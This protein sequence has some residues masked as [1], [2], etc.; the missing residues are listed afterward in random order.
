MNAKLNWKIKECAYEESFVRTLSRQVN[1]SETF[2]RLCL[3]RGLDS[4]EKI[5]QFVSLE[6]PIFHD[7]FLL[8]DMEKIVDR[9]Q[10][11][12]EMGEEIVIYGDYDADGITSTTILVETLE[13]L[14]AHVGYYLPNRFTDGYGPNVRAFQSLIDRGAQLILTCDNGVSGHEAIA[15]ANT[16]GVDVV[17]TDHHELP[18]VLPEAYAI[19]H[20]RHPGASYPF[21]DLSGAGVALKL[22]AAL[23]GEIPYESLDVAAIGT[24]ADLVSLVDEN[25]WIASK[26][27]QQMRRTERLGLRMLL[28]AAGGSGEQVDEETIGFV[29]GP[30]L[31]ALG[32]LEDASPG[33][34]LLLTFEEGRAKELAQYTQTMNSK[35]QAL[36]AAISEEAISRLADKP[37]L[38][39]I[40]VLGDAGWH[41][42]VL[43][44]VASRIVEETGRPAILL[45]FD[46]QTGLAKGSA[47]SIDAVNIFQGLSRCADLLVKFGGHHM[48]AG[49]TVEIA[50]LPLLEQR[51][52]EFAEPFQVD[53]AKGQTIYVDEILDLRDA[54]L[55]FLAEMEKLKPFG[56]KN[57][58]PIFAFKDVLLQTIRQ[59]GADNKHLKFSLAS[60][61]EAHAALDVIAF[62]KGDLAPHLN[63][64][65]TVSAIGELKVNSWRDIRK[66]QL[67]LKDLKSDSR[68]IFDRRSS[69]FQ[70][71]SLEI[72]QATYLFF[73]KKAYNELKD[74]IPSTSEAVLLEAGSAF[75]V[76]EERDRVVILDCP[77]DL[78]TLR[79]FLERNRPNNLYVYAYPLYNATKE[80]M[81]T[82][83]QFAALYRYVQTHQRMAIREN[84]DALSQ[85]LKI[86]KNLLVFMLIVFLEAKFVT[87]ENGIM[88]PVP[89][90]GK[91]SLQETEAYR[92]RVKNIEAEKLFIYSP[93]TRIREWLEGN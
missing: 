26:G 13:I 36:V 82:K 68:Q 32:R 81:P 10:Q 39:D 72:E 92:N 91:V 3:Q 64:A 14:G 43:G 46:Q 11:A 93:F 66:P 52:A 73:Q 20:P 25:R 18:A 56:T 29:I 21:G 90:P 50:K 12:I 80:G 69:R 75:G 76:T 15:Y 4:P 85:F 74:A 19:L 5:N 47:R 88:D 65:D 61:S 84:L 57:E 17:V 23:L 53:I 8:H 7:P 31:N 41:E 48:A 37:S 70:P 16:R 77:S 42:G 55:T 54:S 45:H 59:I 40:I 89:D 86:H 6:E 78:E 83:Q 71:E 58:K 49:L 67:D 22:A 1:A 33:V 79:A 62:N 34:E 27:I 38:P 9:L 35:R 24:I 87:I 30:R 2:V 51:L 44:I 63:E 28:E 60:A